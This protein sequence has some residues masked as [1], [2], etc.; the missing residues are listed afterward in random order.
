M[1]KLLYILLL[2]TTSTSKGQFFQVQAPVAAP[3][4]VVAKF[5]FS[6]A[7][8][9]CTG[10]NN[11]VGN[12]ATGVRSASDASGIGINTVA[13][14]NWTAFSGNCAFDAGGTQSGTFF[15]D[16]AGTASAVMYNSYVNFAAIN[17]SVAQFQVTGCNPAKQYI[18]KFSGSTTNGSGISRIT[19]FEIRGLTLSSEFSYNPHPSGA[20]I[21]D[22]VT[23][24]AMSPD[25]SGN[26]LIYFYN[27]TSAGGPP[28]AGPII[29]AATIAQQ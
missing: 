6:L 25:A 8:H 21:S 5:N 29:G 12:P 19:G 18:F 20:N 27:T 13:T 14:A 17:T 4:S 24:T 1:K 2:F 23:T 15:P 3:P 28:F 9:A 16:C 22:G 7:A 11:V 26:F 10:W